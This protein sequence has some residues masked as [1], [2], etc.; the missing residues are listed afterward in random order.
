TAR[1]D[2]AEDEKAT[3]SLFK[4]NSPSVV[5]I[6]T[7]RSATDIRT[8]NTLEIPAGT[9]SGFIW[10][11]AGHIVTNYHVVQGATGAQITLS[12]DGNHKPNAAV[13]VGA[14]PSYD[15]ALLRISAPASELRPIP[16]GESRSLQ[17]GQKVFAIGNPF[18]LDQSLTTG[19][20]SALG[21]QI[22]AVT[23]RPIDD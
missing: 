19:V 16:L 15:M 18:G 20:V 14:A 17:V 9:G 12:L 8:L 22:T 21:R 13:V 6:T 11:N 2:L 10:D 7:L 3:I 23:G 4:E 1:G 5:Y